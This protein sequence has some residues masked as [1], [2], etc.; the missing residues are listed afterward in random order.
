MAKCA[1]CS[2]SVIVRSGPNLPDGVYEMGSLSYADA[3]K[4]GW[5]CDT[6]EKV[7]CGLC[8]FPRWCEMKAETGLSA[9]ALARQIENSEDGFF[10]MPKCPECG[11]MVSDEVP[12]ENG[13]AG[14][15][16]AALVI[17]GAAIAGYFFWFAD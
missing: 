2:R 13:V 14:C 7:Y 3:E 6:C 1:Q 5:Y 15:V 11:K 8:C 10:E 12:G 9:A 17:I 16:I 4:L